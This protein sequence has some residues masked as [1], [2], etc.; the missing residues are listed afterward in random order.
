METENQIEQS[1]SIKLIKN[2][3][4]FGWEIRILSLNIDKMVEL[5]NRMIE[6]FGSS[7]E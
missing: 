6:K 3:K 2:T 4:G 7:T 5:N 1:E